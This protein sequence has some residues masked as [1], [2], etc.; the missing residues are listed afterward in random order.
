MSDKIQDIVSFPEV[1]SGISLDFIHSNNLDEIENGIKDTVNGVIFSKKAICI[2]LAH[3]KE[4]ELYK[5]IHVNS[6]KKYLK[7]ERIPINYSTALDYSIIG[8]MLIKYEPELKSIDFNE[9]KGLQKLLLLEKG[10]NNYKERPRVVFENIKVKSY[11]DFKV[12]VNNH[13]NKVNTK[14]DHRE[15]TDSLHE[16]SIKIEDERIFLSP[17]G[18]DILWLNGDVEDK[19]GVPGFYREFKKYIV[20]CV[21]E[22]IKMY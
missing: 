22:F 21:E 12:F 4:K 15:N 20:K 18:L 16:V 13:N 5:Q 11:R 9:E 3:I 14:N 19:L 7:K 10:L 1:N 6:F 2:A 8:E 17:S